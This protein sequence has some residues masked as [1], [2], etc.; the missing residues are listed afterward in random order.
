MILVGM[1]W[2]EEVKIHFSLVINNINC[3]MT[4]SWWT[5]L[6]CQLFY[7]HFFD[8]WLHINWWTFPLKWL[9]I[10]M[11]FVSFDNYWSKL[12]DI[13]FVLFEWY[14]FYNKKVTF[15]KFVLEQI[16]VNSSMYLEKHHE[17]RKTYIYDRKSYQ[18]Y[19]LFIIKR[20]FWIVVFNSSIN[21]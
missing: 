3:S 17:I 7:K 2:I 18:D 6:C 12:I 11:I 9:C 15:S 8:I 20:W 14:L 21:R 4:N 10:W 1:L 19:F 5:Q 16:C 13:L